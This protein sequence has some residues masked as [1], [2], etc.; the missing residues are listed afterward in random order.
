MIYHITQKQAWQQA[1]IDDL[2]EPACFTTEGFIHCSTRE[3][4]LGT[5]NYLFSEVHDLVVLCI[6]PTLCDAPVVYENL[7]S[8]QIQFAHLYG[9]LPLKAVTKVVDIRQDAQ[10][11]YQLPDDLV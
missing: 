7:D 9:R 5:A 11:L 6:D 1:Q 2:Y 3:Q 8:G 4:L 10:G